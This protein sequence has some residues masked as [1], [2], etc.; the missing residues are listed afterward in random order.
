[1]DG[2]KGSIRCT[3]NTACWAPHSPDANVRRVSC[4]S[5]QAHRKASFDERLRTI[6]AHNADSTQTY[7]RGVNPLTDRTTDELSSLHGL[8]RALLFAERAQEQT[9]ESP[10]ATP[11]KPRAASDYPP[12]IDWRRRGAV[13]PVKNQGS[14]GSCWSFASAEAVESRWF[15]KT[16]ELQ[17]LS[18]QFILDCTP[19]PHD[20]GGSGG[21]GGGTAKLAYERLAA[22]GGL[23]SEWTYPYLSV[24]GS[25]GRCRGLPLRPAPAPLRPALEKPHA[26]P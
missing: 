19:N 18:E 15:L 1:M 3:R 8:D 4:A 21:C 24:D 11:P 9:L 23:P 14:C 10:P 17:E 16:G 20:C 5:I 26:R 25:A 2:W 6:K 12:G 7:K 22:L 13:T